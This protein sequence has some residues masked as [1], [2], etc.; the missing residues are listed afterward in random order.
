MED[1]FANGYRE[2][3]I[4]AGPRYME[5]GGE[6]PLIAAYG[7]GSTTLGSAFACLL[8]ALGSI[9][10]TLL[11]LALASG[12]ILAPSVDLLPSNGGP[13]ASPPPPGWLKEFACVT[14]DTPAS[15]SVVMTNLV[16][17][18]FGNRK[19]SKVDPNGLKTA[20]EAILPGDVTLED[21]DVKHLDTGGTRVCVEANDDAHA[22]ALLQDMLDPEFTDDL[23]TALGISEVSILDSP[24]LTLEELLVPP[25]AA[26]N[27]P[28]S[29]PPPSIVITVQGDDHPKNES[30]N[31]V[32]VWADTLTTLEFGGV[33][34]VE[35]YD[36]AFLVPAADGKCTAM[37]VHPD[38]SG[39][40]DED[41]TFD[42][43]LSEGEYHLCLRQGADV[44]YYPY[45]RVIA[46][47]RPPGTPSSVPPGSPS[48]VPQRPPPSS[49][50]P[51]LPSSPG[52]PPP[53]LVL[54]VIGVE[55]D[56]PLPTQED[57]D[58]NTVHVNADQ[59]T[60]ID[61]SVG[62]HELDQFDACYWEEATNQDCTVGP[63]VPPL[64]SFLDEN[65]H[66]VYSIPEGEWYLCCRENAQITAF[67]H[68]T[69]IS[70]PM[71]PRP[72]PPPSHP[73]ASPSPTSPPPEAPLPTSPPPSSP[74]PSTP[75]HSPPPL[76]PAGEP[77]VPHG[78]PPGSPPPSKPP[79]C[80]PPPSPP[81]PQSPP[82]PPPPVPSS[83]PPHL[84]LQVI[85]VEGDDPLPTQEDT[86]ENTVHVNAN[87][88]T[89]IDFSVG[90]HELSRYDQCYWEEATNPECTVGPIAPQ[91]TSFLDAN[92][93]GTYTLPEGEWYL[94][95]RENTEIT[96]F[97]HIT[98][99]SQ[100]MVPR[101]PPP[102]GHPPASPSPTSPPPGIPSPSSPPPSAP[103]PG[104]PPPANPP[105]APFGGP[106]Y[107][108]VPKL[109][110]HGPPPGSPPPSKPPP[111]PP[112]PSPPPPQTAT[113]AAP[114]AA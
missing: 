61:F 104:T 86:D 50:P 97:H 113:V 110:P 93:H 72:P 106:S 12:G 66:G 18:L 48:S 67:H 29:A 49:P 15:T 64:T 75:P 11:A 32:Y 98:A 59:P 101:P 47:N 45:I 77:V 112:P 6:D 8:F 41:L 27:Q 4:G 16:H 80:P 89:T 78:P 55:G 24:I 53:H 19:L 36:Y 34:D 42:A 87:Q 102:P 111:C 85:G 74:P 56:D 109:P 96:A 63:I 105:D 44:V 79:P 82:S 114:A 46:S 26:S 73:P 94:C 1:D 60:T 58:E 5:E 2:F 70:Q 84:V 83:P 92:L 68:I 51:P 10:V 14:I 57:T 103:P 39:F 31:D 100:P 91:L 35:E 62:G 71:V 43:K 28:P 95:C 52:T 21:I 25:P 81:L 107:P 90:G 9:I 37:P 76:W 38:R 30:V 17:R 3:S 13:S 7:D 22:D 65:L 99:I 40:L 88:Q 20:L 108:P 33:H 23:A 54:Q 69:A